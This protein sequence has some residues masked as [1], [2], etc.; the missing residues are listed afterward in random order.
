M[1]LLILYH[2][3]H[4]LADEKCRLEASMRLTDDAAGQENLQ[5]QMR[6]V[7]PLL[8]DIRGEILARELPATRPT[9]AAHDFETHLYTVLKAYGALES[10]HSA[11]GQ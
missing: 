5:Q 10:R 9:G 8:V 11:A 6:H 7:A 3:L 2:L 4:D 1:N